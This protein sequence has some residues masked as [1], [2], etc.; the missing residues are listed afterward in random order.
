MTSHK[1]IGGHLGWLAVSAM[2]IGLTV[3]TASAFEASRHAGAC[4]TGALT[5]ALG[6]TGSDIWLGARQRVGPWTFSSHVRVDCYQG[7]CRIHTGRVTHAAGE[8]AWDHN[9]IAMVFQR[10]DA[11]E[12]I[13][14]AGSEALLAAM[15]EVTRVVY[16]IG[17]EDAA[18][19]AQTVSTS[20]RAQ[21]G[22]YRRV[23]IDDGLFAGIRVTARTSLACSIDGLYC[24]V[25]ITTLT[26]VAAVPGAA[27]PTAF[28]PNGS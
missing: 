5:S 20:W 13:W 8:I 24:E 16:R 10:I 2:A 7:A 4:E 19:L 26:E 17:G 28:S 9:D 1:A 12:S 23:F 27:C 22:S 14:F 15:P 21:D 6:D 25:D 3:S 18:D 11:S